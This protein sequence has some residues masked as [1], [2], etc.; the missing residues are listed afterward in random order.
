MKQGDVVNVFP[1]GKPEQKA[2]GTI[3]ILSSNER[4][5]AVAFDDKPPFATIHRDGMF[6][7]RDGGKL[8]FFATREEV[9]PW[10][11]F[12]RQ[13]HYE[14]EPFPTRAEVAFLEGLK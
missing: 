10:V 12:M 2:L 11:E 5:I 4:Q 8:M 14:I 13:G 1:H 9:G 6:L 3:V 7:T